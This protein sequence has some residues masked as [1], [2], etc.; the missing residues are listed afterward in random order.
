MNDFISLRRGRVWRL[1]CLI[2]LSLSSAF[3]WTTLSNIIAYEAYT[4]IIPSNIQHNLRT[5]NDMEIDFRTRVTDLL[6]GPDGILP[7]DSFKLNLQQQTTISGQLMDLL[8]QM[9]ASNSSSLDSEGGYVVVNATDSSL[10]DLESSVVALY[11]I[12]VFRLSATCEPALLLPA[13]LLVETV[14]ENVVQMLG[15]LSLSNTTTENYTYWYAGVAEDL[16]SS[17]MTWETK[18]YTFFSENYQHV[19]LG[20]WEA[21]TG[22]N[23]FQMG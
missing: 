19:V 17:Y 10:A 12:P 21:D 23:I 4:E 9:A 8:N 1:D 13:S 15:K 20:Y 11:D 22:D 3:S 5:L 16:N 6:R 2:L 18:P 14:I 7:A